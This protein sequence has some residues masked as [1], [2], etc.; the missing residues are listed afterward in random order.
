MFGI[1]LAGVNKMTIKTGVVAFALLS[2]LGTASAGPGTESHGPSQAIADALRAAAGSDAAFIPAGMVKENGNADNL[3]SW[4]QYPTDEIAV[5]DL[6]GSQI[7]AALER[8]VSLYPSTSMSFLQLSGIDAA[9]SKSAPADKRIVSASI[10]GSKL[11]DG[12]TYSVAMPVSLA[13]GGY[14]YFK[15]WEKSQLTRTLPGVTLESLLKG[16]KSSE[17][18]PRWTVQN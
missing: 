4:L 8:S 1:P 10:N 9:F 3:A 7:R 13:R 11:E 2:L 16:K 15:I 12:R 14:G 6:K 17:T 18:S 5:V